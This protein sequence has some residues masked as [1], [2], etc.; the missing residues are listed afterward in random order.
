MDHSHHSIIQLILCSVRTSEQISVVTF[1][2]FNSPSTFSIWEIFS[3]KSGVLFIQF[4]V[5]RESISIIFRSSSLKDMKQMVQL[6]NSLIVKVIKPARIFSK[7][8]VL[9]PGGG[10]ALESDTYWEANLI[11]ST[12]N[13]ALRSSYLERFSFPCR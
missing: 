6:Q 4:Q 5:L 7:S 10:C 8:A 13:S 9:L 12:G 3:I 11:Y 1:T 2:E